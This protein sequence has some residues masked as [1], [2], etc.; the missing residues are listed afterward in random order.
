MLMDETVDR[1][2]LD[3]QLS[4]LGRVAPWL[5][6]L[7]DRH[8]LPAE[9]RY[10]ID[11]CLEEALANVVLHGYGNEPGHPITVEASVAGGSLFFSIEDQG[12]PFAPPDPGTRNGSQPPADLETIEVGGNGIRLMYR[13]AGSV[14]YEPLPR[15]NRLTLGF[16]I[17]AAKNVDV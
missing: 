5:E 14:S 15:G 10:A 7:A 1:L 16:P 6:E 11:L 17:P 9:T 4:E 8:E 3:S 2:E 12:P 13:F